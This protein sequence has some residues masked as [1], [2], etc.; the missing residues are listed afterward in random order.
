ML[1]LINYIYAFLV[2][3]HKGELNMK[4]YKEKKSKIILAV[5][6]SMLMIGTIFPNVYANENKESF[7]EI[8][9]FD[10]RDDIISVTIP[11]GTY[12][13]KNTEQ[14]QEISVN[15]LGRLLVPGKPNL[16]SKIF[17]VAIPPG[18]ELSDV[19][20]K[21][22]DGILLPGTYEISPSPLPR[23][24]GEEDPM[25][26]EKERK[27]Y[28]INYNTVY[29]S[30]A[31]YPPSIVEVV[32]TGGYRKYNLV[33]IRITP[34]T[35]YPLS[36]K[37]MY[38]PEVT[39]DVKYSY[40]EDF[41]FGSI[42]VDNL[43]YTEQTAEK[44][45]LNYDKAKAWYPKDT[46]SRSVY[47]Y[48]IITL[49]SL[50]SSVTPL[51]DWEESKGRSVKVVNTSWIDSNYDGWD[52]AEKIRNFLREKYPMEEWGIEY[53]CLI[54]DYD[55]VPIRTTY[56][57]IEDHGPPAT[58]YYYAELSLPDNESWDEN[59]NH[60][61]GENSDSIDFYTEVNVGRIPWSDPDIVEHICEK[62]AAYEQ[63]E[64]PSFRKNI[65]LL[66][67]FFWDNNPWP[68]T[69]N[70]VLMEAKV[71]QDWMED[72]T[73]TR[74]YEEGY[75]DYEMD[76]DL[77]YENV[78]T[79]WSEGSYG[80]V[81]WAGHGSP[82]ACYRMH[83]SSKFVDT[84][85]CN[86]LNDDYP[87]IIFADACSNSDT[88]YDNIGKMMLKQG[89]VG[90]LG[91]T[92]VAFGCPAWEDPYDGSS[93]SLDYF[94]T[95]CVTSG[96]YTQGQAQQ[97]ALLEMYTNGLWSYTNYEMFQWGALWGNPDLAML[98]PL[99]MIKFP[100]GLPEFID[101]DVS[102]TITVQIEEN[103][104]T[105]IPGTGKIYYR[106]NGGTYIES[107][108]EPLG[109]DLYEATLP[110]P[111]CGDIPEYYFSA[112][113]EKAGIIYSPSDSPDNTYTAIVGKLIPVFT[114]DFEINKG[115]VVK[116]DEYLTAGAWDRG[117]PAGGGSRGDPPNDYD[118][119]G[120]CYITDNRF[121][122]SDVDD[123][124]TWLIS[125]TMDL[126][127]GVDARVNYALWYTNN[128]GNDPNNDLF[129]VYVSNNDG[130][131]WVEAES[132]GPITSGGWKERGFWVSDFVTPT[133]QVKVRFEASDLNDGS[134][135]EAGVDSFSAA[136]Y[137][138]S[139]EVD[140]DIKINGGMGVNTVITNNGIED[141][142]DLNMELHVEGGILG[143][144]DKTINDTVDIPAGESKTLS[145]GLLLGFGGIDI[146]IT[147]DIKEETAKGTQL[148]FFTIIK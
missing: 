75:S 135:V 100:D 31:P 4:N 56:Q 58:D 21:T 34:F 130:A 144:I 17:A 77:T 57:Y 106:Y 80:F 69:D 6:F 103:A 140:L 3:K 139:S 47:D 118:G 109:D 84:N 1:F 42:M 10:I 48:V 46:V 45:I 94:F 134:V 43:V 5:L 86:Y 92:C 129:K 39:I 50:T 148:I 7:E 105:Y 90:F 142:E 36:G 114:D 66:G 146:M 91:A 124:I 107:A 119:S 93:Q 65:L 30:N 27:E 22:G 38:Y 101:P 53:V 26:Y 121:G 99:L 85:T 89:A 40:P 24:I 122:D 112:Q 87:A 12:E 128:Y 95:T 35:Y 61:Y 104:D 132:I 55:D 83:P 76:Y 63:N 123:G 141:I 111:S 8:G 113:G 117:T 9:Y 14:G 127:G 23:V 2:I 116:N 54:G 131:S 81:N 59:G 67:A 96:E 25:I 44:I 126:E 32:R 79:V 133:D 115:W 138:C 82:T 52:L 71:D 73:M 108:L 37:L 20:F 136:L 60:L 137:Q 98:P 102:T 15:N 19:S 29:G 72:W 78:K 125:P 70:A 18:A 11:I 51:V 33:D 110:P 97:W 28:E 88:H 13:I 143:L 68:R 62:S 120:K 74:L 16:P 41:S 49:D 147:S 145:T 64:D